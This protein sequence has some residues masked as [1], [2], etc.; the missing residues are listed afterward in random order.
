M[1]GQISNQII[2]SEI[3]QKGFNHTIC[4][5]IALYTLQHIIYL[6]PPSPE[7]MRNLLFIAPFFP[8]PRFLT[9]QTPSGPSPVIM[10]TLQ[11]LTLATPPSLTP[12]D[13]PPYPT[14]LIFFFQSEPFLSIPQLPSLHFTN[15]PAASS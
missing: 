3:N 9:R 6:L 7:Q 4:Y 5:T 12:T 10:Y 15:L 8:V 2:G 14:D 1:L 11:P 13:R